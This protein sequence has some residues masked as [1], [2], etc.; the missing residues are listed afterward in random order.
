VER[1]RWWTRQGLRDAGKVGD[2]RLDA[3]TLAFNLGLKPL[4][5]VTVEGI[6]DILRHVSQLHQKPEGGRW[7]VRTLRMLIVAILTEEHCS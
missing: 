5:L 1:T 4:H 7:E 6:G 2:D 3:I